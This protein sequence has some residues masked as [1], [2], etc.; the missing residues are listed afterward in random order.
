MPKSLLKLILVGLLSAVQPSG[1]SAQSVIVRVIADHTDWVYKIGEKA[2]F[3]VEVLKDNTPLKDVHIKYEIGLERMAPVTTGDLILGDA[4]QIINGGSLKEPGFLRCI[5]TTNIEGKN[6]RGLATAAFEPEHIRP[7]TEMPE[8]FLA[9]WNKAKAEAAKIPMD[10][11]MTLLSDKCTETVNVYEVGIQNYRLGSRIY[12]ILSI[13][14]KEGKYPAIL[15]VPGA[16]VG[17]YSADIS[18]SEKGFIVLRIEI[19]GLPL[20]L[21]DSI[22][23]KLAAGRLKGYP[24][25]NY[26]NRDEYYFK[27][28]FM[29]CIRAVDYLCSLPQFDGKDLAV[30]GGS[31]G[32]ALTIATTALDNRVKYMVAYFPGLSDLTGY[33][34][35]RA[36]GW[37][38]MLKDASRVTQKEIQTSKYY[39]MA[40][41]A[42]LIKVPGFYSWGFNDETCPPTTSYAVYNTI[43]APKE[44]LIIKESGHQ[45]NPEQRVRMDSWLQEKLTGKK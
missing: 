12:G 39:D 35:G 24:L 44:L 10:A 13:P 41:F 15:K 43:K 7:T 34:H 37:P 25:F 38:H 11:H 23:K 42:R 30:A 22:Y 16:G 20:T 27:R 8:D 3:S 29:G 31:Q 28:V 40:N 21:P 36:G 19:H 1:V 26:D 32:G 2:I 17:R 33:L 45:Y 5:V 9:F 18:M 14:K 4:K 6:Y